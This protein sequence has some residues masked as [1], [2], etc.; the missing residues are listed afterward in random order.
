MALELKYEIT[1]SPE[2]DILF[3]KD[4]TGVY[5]LNNTG[6]WGTPNIDRN[7]VALVCYVKYNP[8]SKPLENLSVGETALSVIDYNATH[9]NTFQTTFEIAYLKDGFYTVTV[10]AVPT[11]N[12]T[13]TL[14]DI[15]YDTNLQALQIWNGTGFVNL[16]SEDWEKLVDEDKYTLVTKNELFILN[17]TCKRNELLEELLS[18]YQ[19]TSCKCG[20]QE[21]ELTRLNIFLQGADYRFFS[22]KEYEAQRMIEILTRQFKC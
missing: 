2:L 4:V 19:C 16:E 9:P 22:Q 7:S 5:T 14:D 10:V 8:Y 11:E 20:D 12:L 3:I 15:I 18:C 17:L 13:P 21:A 6:G 1:H